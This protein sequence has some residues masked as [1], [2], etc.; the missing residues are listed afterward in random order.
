M[1]LSAK[2]K[3]KT[4]DQ[5]PKQD[6]VKRYGN[7]EGTFVLYV[8]GSRGWIDPLDGKVLMFIV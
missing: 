4:P 2:H 8:D 7:Q 6:I 1:V 3:G 5:I